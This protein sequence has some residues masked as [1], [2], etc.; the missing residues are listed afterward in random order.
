MSITPSEVTSSPAENAEG[1]EV[2]WIDVYG[3]RRLEVYVLVVALTDETSAFPMSS[4]EYASSAFSAAL[5]EN[6]ISLREL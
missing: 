3:L 5:S 4:Y 1:A 6:T 2:D